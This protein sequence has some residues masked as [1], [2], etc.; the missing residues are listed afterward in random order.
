M[1]LAGGF[2]KDR[3]NLFPLVQ[4]CSGG[5]RGRLERRAGREDAVAAFMRPGCKTA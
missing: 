4:A 3:V 1:R 2:E 5:K